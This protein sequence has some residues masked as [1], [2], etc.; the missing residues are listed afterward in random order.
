MSYDLI[1]EFQSILFA[2]RMYQHLKNEKR[3]E[4]NTY[5]RCEKIRRKNIID[6]AECRNI[7]MIMDNGVERCGHRICAT[8]EIETT[9]RFD[10]N[11]IVRRI[12]YLALFAPRFSFLRVRRSSSLC[13]HEWRQRKASIGHR[14]RGGKFT[15]A[16][17]DIRSI[18]YFIHA[19]YSAIRHFSPDPFSSSKWTDDTRKIPKTAN[20]NK[21][22][23]WRV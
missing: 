23:K 18:N 6:C 22:T 9:F 11:W 5:T 10:K 20:K 1:N 19:N 15:R 7:G 3:N 21:R 12:R 2:P 14:F 17:F 4:L 13:G 16:F 8:Y